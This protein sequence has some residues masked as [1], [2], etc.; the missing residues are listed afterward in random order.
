MINISE[1]TQE[2]SPTESEKWL[3]RFTQNG[4][5]LDCSSSFYATG[6]GH[7]ISGS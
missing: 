2:S 7:T 6:N 5:K 3:M 1:L 4:V